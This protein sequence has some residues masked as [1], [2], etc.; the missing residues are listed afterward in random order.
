ML[1]ARLVEGGC[2][3]RSIPGMDPRAGWLLGHGMAD[4]MPDG[5]ETLIPCMLLLEPGTTLTGLDGLYFPV[6]VEAPKRLGRDDAPA[7]VLCF[8]A[9]AFFDA[10]AE[11]DGPYRDLHA[12]IKAIVLSSPIDARALP[13]AIGDE[14][15]ASLELPA[16]EPPTCGWPAGTVVIGVI[17][18]GIAFANR[19]FRRSDGK[20]RIEAFWQ[21]G[22]VPATPHTVDVGRELVK[23]Q[24]DQLLQDHTHHGFLDEAELYREAGLVDFGEPGHK[25]AAWR[26]AHGTH[27][28]DLAAALEPGADERSRPIIAVE[29]PTAAVADTSFELL[30]QPILAA[31]A[32][33]MNRA[34]LLTPAGEDPLPVVI[35]FSYGMYAGPHDGT[36]PVEQ[37]FDLLI[38]DD[39]D[40]RAIVLP[41][42]NSHL[43]RCHA[44]IVFP[45][46]PEVEVALPWRVL[47][48][49]R[50]PSSVEVW[51]PY[52]GNPG[53]PP[54]RVRLAL[55]PPHGL[56]GNAPPV[57][58]GEDQT[59]KLEIVDTAGRVL[60]AACYTFVEGLTQRGVFTIELQPTARLAPFDPTLAEAPAGVWT[61]R[62][63]RQNLPA[64]A[65]LEAWIQRDDAP[66]GYPIRGR[67]S[68]FDAPRYVRYDFRGEPVDEDDHDEQV[69]AGDVPIRRDAQ[70]NAIASGDHV[71]VA[72][73][74]QRRENRV[75]P[76]S[77]G[78][79]VT[80]RA[81][82]ALDE[83]RR[84]PDALAMS[85]D[86][87]ALRGVLAAGTASGSVVAF[88][89]TSIAA[90]QLA[91][92]VANRLAANLQSDRD[93][94]RDDVL[95]GNQPPARERQ[96]WGLIEV[97]PVVSV[98]R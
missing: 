25:A 48:D 31:I 91:R 38:E 78:G 43:E 56:A 45:A 40:R 68:Y 4:F 57:W 41:S 90:P 70:L 47:P 71:L 17:D 37:A 76:Y 79:P 20:T 15:P 63:A 54:S 13:F 88:T 16:I 27:V 92:K 81:G 8:A 84:K 94:L 49:D 6:T 52:A 39:P 19:R 87:R 65:R 11:P 58:L 96:G 86:S 14:P 85:D 26:A 50:T 66:Y 28:L 93:S 80:P 89:G 5:E 44:S 21:Q 60:A 73:S 97:P 24:I 75:A 74:W 7:V 1:E 2:G 59:A 10:L 77:A 46:P 67:Q 95:D 55:V 32:Y 9:K 69:A 35:C 83:T 33:I 82:D 22:A 12:R 23:T 64:D 34:A 18:D 98:P 42:G 62:L 72:G 3:Y 36:H 61:I 53:Q 29:L 30:T 51:L